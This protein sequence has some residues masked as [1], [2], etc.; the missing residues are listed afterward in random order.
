MARP[1][2]IPDEMCVRRYGIKWKPITDQRG[3]PVLVRQDW[4]IERLVL[5]D[6]DKLTATPGTQLMDWTEHFKLFVSHIWGRP[7]CSRKFLWNPYADRMLREARANKFLGISGH[8]SSGKTEF[9][10]IWGLANFLIYPETT[11]VFV[12]STTLTESRMRVWGVIEAYWG[13]AEKFFAPYGWKPGKLVSSAGKITGM[14][15]GKSNDLTGL[16]LIAGGKGQDG[17]AS[18]KIGFKAQNVILIADELPLLTHKLYE[19][20]SGNLF[21]NENFQ[22]VGIGNLTSIFDPFGVF[23]EPKAGWASLTEDMYGW[24]TKLGYC[25]RFSGENSPNVL[26]GSNAYPGLLTLDKLNAYKV[27]LGTKSPE[28]Y[29]MVLSFPCPTGVVDS[30]YSEPEL[31]AHN[32]A[33]SGTPWLSRPTPLAFLDPSFSKG[34]DRAAAAFGLL[35]LTPHPVTRHPIQ[36]LEKTD[37]VDLMM[38]VNAR[39]K[40][41]DRN[42]QLADLFIAE[43]NKRGVAIADR[44]VDSTGGGD[45][46]ATICAMKMGH[47]MQLVSFAGAASDKPISSTDTR[48]GKDRFWNRVAELWYIGKEFLLGGQIRGLDAATMMELCARTYKNVGSKVKV[49]TKDDMKERTNGRSC[50]LGDAWAGL[51]EIA[52]RRHG[53]IP[54]ARSAMVKQPV[55]PA[56]D[57]VYEAAWGHITNPKKPT[58]RDHDALPSL[59]GSSGGWGD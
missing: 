3:R 17:D 38:Q 18:T 10:A 54:A 51:V 33:K 45:P 16:A 57:P 34:G 29:R 9:G 5:M 41:K 27:N 53:F 20:A 55:G 48:K 30:I 56:K 50:D 39:H 32:A 28:Y 12:T 52:R 59:A 36:V 7:E 37:T 21:A 23:A 8:A 13:E 24:E 26:S 42:E 25:I 46:F 47:G 19:S 15:D 31:V 4:M 22:M 40:D 2:T 58:F 6:Y 44:G 11:K 49:E 35:G 1:P 14:R 43:C